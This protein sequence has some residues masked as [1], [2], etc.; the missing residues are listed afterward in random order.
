M[1]GLSRAEIER[2]AEQRGRDIERRETERLLYRP[3]ECAEA[4]GAS[5]SQ[6]Y[7]L[8]AKGVL[9]SIRLGDGS[10]RV[11]VSALRAW[12]DQQLAARAV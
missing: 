12:I 1:D 8:I 2:R 9:P 10:I 3:R 5:V 7:A 4:I 11:P 6:T